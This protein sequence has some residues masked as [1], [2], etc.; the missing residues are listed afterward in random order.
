VCHCAYVD[1]FHIL[2][3]L[4][5]PK[6]AQ[7][8]SRIT[9]RREIWDSTKQEQ[10]QKKTKKNKKNNKQHGPHNKIMLCIRLRCVGTR[11][12]RI[13]CS[14]RHRCHHQRTIN[15]SIRHNSLKTTCQ[16]VLLP[17]TQDHSARTRCCSDPPS[18]TTPTSAAVTTTSLPD[19]DDDAGYLHDSDLSSC[20]MR[21]TMPNKHHR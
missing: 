14:Y 7:R 6:C 1:S 16:R 19:V 12:L 2:A 3:S 18:S 8:T 11:S 17:P 4:S 10:E 5:E 9:T 21:T 13:H 20:K 15:A